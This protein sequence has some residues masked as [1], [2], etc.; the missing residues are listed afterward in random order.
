MNEE[1]LEKALAYIGD[2][3]KND[4]SG[5]DFYHSVR[6]YKLATTIC[7]AENADLEIVQLASLLHDVDD[8]KIF[9]GKMGDFSNAESFL[10]HN[11][12]SKKK[13]N[14]ICEI[15]ATISFKGTATQVPK[16]QEGKIVQDADRLDA[17]GA[18]GIARVF[19]Y[20]G[21]NNRVLHI[22]DM[23]P[24]D[25]MNAEQYSNYKGTSIN[26]FYEKLL[27]LRDLMN[28][29]AAKKLAESR[30][31]YMQVFLE[32]FSEEWDGEK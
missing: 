8:Y 17:M 28:T 27:K 2:R 29:K 3:F 13:I 18:I 20:G 22:P 11:G 21:N 23:S 24:R 30:H 14:I 16:S 7:K 31:R 32:E 5:H 26:H 12:M 9:G 1:L 25:E 19:A 4:Y 6:V 15:I 10:K